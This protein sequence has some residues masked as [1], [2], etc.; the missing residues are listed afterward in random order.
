MTKTIE[1]AGQR[2]VHFKLEGYLGGKK[3]K[4]NLVKKYNH[5]ATVLADRLYSLI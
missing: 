3:K 2:E 5:V 1:K 4:I